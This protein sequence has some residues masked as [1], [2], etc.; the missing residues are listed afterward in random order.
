[1]TRT[2]PLRDDA[3]SVDRSLPESGRDWVRNDLTGSAA[4]PGHLIRSMIALLPAYAGIA[5]LLPGSPALRAA[6]LVLAVL[7]A[8]VDSLAFIAMNTPDAA[9]LSVTVPRIGR[10]TARRVGTNMSA[11]STN[12]PAGTGKLGLPSELSSGVTPRRGG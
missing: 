11:S 2:G 7:L 1:M 4:T 3:D 10:I 8:L 5:L 6:A 12:A 9:R